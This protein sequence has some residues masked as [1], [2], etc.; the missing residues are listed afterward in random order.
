MHHVFV[1]GSLMRGLHNH[2][3]LR[4]ARL[5]EATLT[6]SEHSLVDL[7]AFPGVTWLPLAWEHHST[8]IKGELYEV[9][10]PTLA[11]LDRLEGHP[12]FY[13]RKEVD[14][15]NGATAWMYFLVRPDMDHHPVLTGDWRRY[16][17]DERA[18]TRANP[19]AGRTW[20][21]SE[22]S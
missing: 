1:Y 12:R 21:P 20:N 10:D 16:C 15:Q 9:D 11:L 6:V 2:H 4:T 22:R 7:G 13:E 14:L 18:R 19:L 8:P 3:Y 5:V 17:A